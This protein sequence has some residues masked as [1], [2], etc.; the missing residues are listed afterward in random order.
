MSVLVPSQD[1]LT[2]RSVK[3]EKSFQL[4]DWFL[5]S[6]F[7]AWKMV[8]IY[9]PSISPNTVFLMVGQVLTNEFHICH[10]RHGSAP[11]EVKLSSEIEMPDEPDLRTLQSFRNSKSHPLFRFRKVPKEDPREQR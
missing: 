1:Q 6:E 10:K 2:R 9:Y 7:Q 4:L 11:C 3:V 8:D 5:A